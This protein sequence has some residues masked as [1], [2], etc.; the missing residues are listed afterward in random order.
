MSPSEINTWPL[1]QNIF[2]ENI[3]YTVF[4]SILDTLDWIKPQFITREEYNQKKWDILKET[5]KDKEWKTYTLFMPTDLKNHELPSIIFRVNKLSF[6]NEIPEYASVNEL[7]IKITLAIDLLLSEIKTK[8]NAWK[9][10]KKAIKNYIRL[11]SQMFPNINPAQLNNLAFRKS[12]I[13]SRNLKKYEQ[14]T[15]KL[16][17][18]K[19]KEKLSDLQEEL[20]K[21]LSAE[22]WVHFE[23]AFYERW[24]NKLSL[25]L[26]TITQSELESIREKNISPK[27]KTVERIEKSKL[28]DKER[29][30]RNKIWITKLKKDLQK[31]RETWDVEQIAKKELEITNSVLKILHE[32]PYQLTEK[33]Y[34]YQPKQIL[35]NKEIYCVWFSLIWSS[36]LSEL[37]IKHK[38]LEIP[39]HSALEINIWWKKYYFD[40]TAFKKIIEFTY[41]AKSWV[42]SE[43]NLKVKNSNKNTNGIFHKI[44]TSIFGPDKKEVTNESTIYSWVNT[45]LRKI[46]A[47]SWNPEKILLSQIYNNRWW[48]LLEN[49]DYEWAIKIFHKALKLTPNSSELYYNLWVVHGRVWND[50]EAIKMSNLAIKLN[51]KSANW[52]KALWLYY[53][54][55]WEY[56]ESE[57]QL[58]KALD[59]NYYDPESYNFIWLT[60]LKLWKYE[61]AVDKLETALK[62]KP[63]KEMYK[64]NL[65]TA[66]SMLWTYLW[67][68]WKYIEAITKIDNALKLNPRNSTAYNNKSNIFNKQWKHKTAMLNRYVGSNLNYYKQLLIRKSYSRNRRNSSNIWLVY[69]KEYAQINYYLQKRDYDSLRKYMLMLSS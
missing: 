3:D 38:W 33:N 8:W 23:E 9:E 63:D 54:N 17:Q 10:V 51:P 29:L 39:G 18:I 58:N 48:T 65:S 32:Y 45:R 37:W 1:E 27:D 43:I 13:D 46:L 4:E 47:I 50:E 25:W 42:Y 41:W 56:E 14:Y 12:I 67:E 68:S 64:I 55:I 31:I 49:M 36:F 34:W 57:K 26:M 5:W 35:K 53:Y 30:L 2:K 15:K 62:I 19:T 59:K 11:F 24:I 28:D 66:M 22:I 7:K 21:L 40:A 69:K 20:D 61:E 60:L 6:P 16:D 44:Y 52:Y